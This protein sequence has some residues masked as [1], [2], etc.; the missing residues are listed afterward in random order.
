MIYAACATVP[1]GV[2]NYFYFFKIFFAEGLK[3]LLVLRCKRYNLILFTCNLFLWM[4]QLQF[5]DLHF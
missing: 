5:A 4:I 2:K 3:W 1:A